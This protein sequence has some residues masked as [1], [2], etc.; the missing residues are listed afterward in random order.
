MTSS[1]RLE[2]IILLGLLSFFLSLPLPLLATETVH[3][4]KVIGVTDGDTIKILERR[5][6]LKVR[7]AEIDA[8]ET[9]Q[10]FGTQ[11]KKALSDLIF[12]KEVR[13]I[14]R[15]HDRYGRMVGIVYADNQNVNMEM[16]RRG[17]AWVYRRYALETAFFQLEEEAKAEKRGLWADPHAIPPW[18]YRHGSGKKESA[19]LEE[20]VVKPV[21]PIIG[22]AQSK[23]Y[24]WQGCPNYRMVSAP[25]QVF[26]K[27]RAEAEEAGFRAA[28]NCP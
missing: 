24:H 21:A 12:G 26:F 4:G 1:L 18:E 3:Y 5:E 28:R 14:E 17:M 15:D 8:P 13:V 7:L 27:T 19:Q 23:I 2:R 6:T 22:N 16:V 9:R 10:A 25:H 11:A 20:I